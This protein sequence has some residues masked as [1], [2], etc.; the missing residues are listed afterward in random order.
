[1]G[2][3]ANNCV[4]WTACSHAASFAGGLICG[5][6][7]TSSPEIVQHLGTKSDMDILVIE[8]LAM[9]KQA[10]GTHASLKEA[11][12]MVKQCVM[13]ETPEEELAEGN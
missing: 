5:I 2:V 4:Q 11:L 6:Y 9:L 13:I 3:M 12:P 10:L 7:Q 1:M 8:N